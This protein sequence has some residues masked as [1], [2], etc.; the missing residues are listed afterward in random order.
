MSFVAD[1][2]RLTNWTPEGN[3]KIV[4]FASGAPAL[5]TEFNELQFIVDKRLR[6]LASMFGDGLL[7]EGT[8]LYQD[9]KLTIDNERAIVGG[10]IFYISHLELD[11]SVGDDVYLD[12]FEKELTYKDVMRKYGNEQEVAIPNYI[13]DSRY[14]KEISRRVI[15][16]YNL[17]T[18]T[19]EDGHSYLKVGHVSESP[20][21]GES[22]E[23]TVEF[24]TD[25]AT[26]GSAAMEAVETLNTTLNNLSEQFFQQS[27]V[28]E[29]MG[30]TIDAQ[31]K[32][33]VALRQ[34]I[35]SFSNIA[36]FNIEVP[37]DGWVKDEDMGEEDSIH[38][39]IP[40]E[41]V[42]ESFVPL[43]TINPLSLTI[44]SK[45]Q[46][47]SVTRTIDGHVRVYAKTVPTEVVDAN[48]VLFGAS[49]II[50]GGNSGGGTTTSYVLPVA[51]KMTLGGI[52]EGEG[53]EIA[54][55]G[56]A[57]VKGAPVLPEQISKEGDAEQ[58]LDEV[59]G[60]KKS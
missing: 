58:M 20:V 7:G 44:A 47:K 52:K 10:N 56:T 6:D 32:E 35:E 14:M 37:K 55:D 24:V 22:G 18:T 42:N 11:V 26:A 25:A 34:M 2:T 12:V 15:L 1:F 46:M 29:E 40:I 49:N 50:G 54:P 53:I 21:P 28:V 4:R 60:P 59:L 16:A 36:A 41:G 5:E 17:V 45:S 39:D 43:L 27:S 19:G 13:I 57:S 31:A 33:I 23:T 3:A 38:V 8:I 30:N 9:G 51:T 48:L